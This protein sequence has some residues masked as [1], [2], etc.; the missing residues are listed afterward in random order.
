MTLGSTVFDRLRAEYEAEWLPQAFVEPTDFQALL[1]HRST[2]LFGASGSGRT[3]LC[4]Q[5]VHLASQDAEGPLIVEWQPSLLGMAG[6]KAELYFAT[7]NQIYDQ[8]AR[9][10]LR[11]LLDKSATFDAIAGWVKETAAWFI[12]AH[13]QGSHKRIL[14]R[15]AED[16]PKESLPVLHYLLESQVELALNPESPDR[17]V[18]AELAD[19]VQRLGWSGLW[20]LVDGLESWLA[21]ETD[22]LLDA[23]DNL[24][25][26]LELFEVPNFS[27]KFFAPRSME[28][29]L[30][31]CGGVLRDRLVVVQLE[32]N[33][34]RLQTIVEKRLALATGENTCPLARI[35]REDILLAWLS[36]YGGSIPRGWLEL[37]RPL[38]DFYLG[39]ARQTLDKA[40][41]E[42]LVARTP[43]RLRI[44][45]RRDRVF[46]AYREIENVPPTGY[47]LLKYIYQHPKRMCSNEELYYL[48]NLKLTRIPL[49][50]QDEKW[51]AKH[52]WR[53]WYDTTLSRLRAAIEP[54]PGNPIYLVTVRGKGIVLKNA[55]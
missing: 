18:I 25:S 2:L 36:E 21:S 46:L 39:D 42:Q 54:D 4:K 29:S 53:S 1:S 20:L 24:L 31:Q 32:W 48:A 19:L 8:I 13:L 7:M 17:L 16:E 37:L 12:Q 34:T 5:I 43:P 33:E 40:T 15:M 30:M 10:L 9:T 22:E 11:S 47:Q 6:S 38:V 51:E 3:A 27:I 55:L 28:A 14:A 50:S 45:L 52:K 41:W 49:G 44:D 35:Y 26:T 23:L